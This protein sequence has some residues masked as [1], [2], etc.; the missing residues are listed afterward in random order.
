MRGG[1]SER[2]EVKELMETEE[3]GGLV[4]IWKFPIRRVSEIWESAFR[5]E[6]PLFF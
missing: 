4:R 3:P 5:A 1:V 2:K 6:P